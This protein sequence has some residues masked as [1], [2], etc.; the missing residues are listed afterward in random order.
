[1]SSSDDLSTKQ[2]ESLKRFYKE[3][4]S[5]QE[6]LQIIGSEDFSNR[7]WGFLGLNGH[8]DRNFSFRTPTILEKFIKETIPRSIY[9]GAVYSAPPDHDRG[10]SIHQVD[11]V[12][13]ELIFDIDLTEYDEVR[14]CDCRGKNQLCE[15]CWELVKTAAFWIQDTLVNDFG[16]REELIHWVFSGRRGI[17]AW[18]TEKSFSELDNEQRTAIIDYLSLIRGAGSEAKLAEELI[19]FPRNLGI[20]VT[21]HIIM[22]FF[23]EASKKTLERLGISSER[24]LFILQQRNSMGIDQIFLERFVYADR[25]LKQKGITDYYPTREE[26]QEKVVLQ[27]APRIDSG[28]SKD[29]RRIL[30]LPGSVHGETGKRV[31]RLDFEALS[32]FSPLDENS[33]FEDGK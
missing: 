5:L 7:E 14:P 17:H 10:I 26:I 28:V 3:E 8:F 1:M 4:F 13:R 29:I 9:V 31:Q 30:R 2:I 25:M 20:R 21:T 24:A 11:W 6:A 15:R 33:I 18:V 16:V 12:R 23:R 27:W 22:P 19:N 32:Y